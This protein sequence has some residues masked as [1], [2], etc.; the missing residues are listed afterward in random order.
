MTPPWL[1]TDRPPERWQLTNETSGAGVATI[2]TRVG[3]ARS[4]LIH[5]RNMTTERKYSGANGADVSGTD[6][7]TTATNR[8]PDTPGAAGEQ[9]PESIRSRDAA[10]AR[11]SDGCR[12][13]GGDEAERSVLVPMNEY[14]PGMTVRVVDRIPAPTVV[15]LL[16]LPNGETV[17]VLT[18]PDE[19]VG[20]VV[21]SELGGAQVRSTMIVFTRESLESGAC[22]AFEAGA[23]M[24]STQLSLLRTTARRIGS[25]D[26]APDGNDE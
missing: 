13:D 9:S 2:E 23:R 18:Q 26:S 19:Y 15:E 16:V 11:S 4:N 12:S 8:R 14:R 17:P 21:R 20:Y 10:E 25:A 22:Y 7:A 6:P 3:E 5:H 24:F 1:P